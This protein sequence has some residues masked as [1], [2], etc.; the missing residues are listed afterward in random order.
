[1]KNMKI[2]AFLLFFLTVTGNV[3]SQNTDPLS[4]HSSRQLTDTSYSVKKANGDSTIFLFER[5]DSASSGFSLPALTSGSVLFSNG[6][7]ISQDNSNL[8]WDNSNKKLGIG[9]SS[10]SVPL[11][12]RVDGLANALSLKSST[13]ASILDFRNANTN[14]TPV[15]QINAFNCMVSLY[16]GLLLRRPNNN[17]TVL[18]LANPS[19]VTIWNAQSDGRTMFGS[20][21]TPS[22]FVHII[23]STGAA[24]MA[25]IK[26]NPGVKLIIPEVGAIE[27]D[28]VTNHLYWTD[29]FINR[30]QLDNDSVVSFSKNT[31]GDSIVLTFQ[32]GKRWAAKDSIGEGNVSLITVSKHQ[33]DSLISNNILIPGQSYMIKGVD[34][35]LY[36]GTDIILKAATV[37]K[38]ELSGHGIFY[39]PKYNQGKEDYGVW[40]NISSWTTSGI[41]G[42]FKGNEAVTAQNG[43]KGTT[44]ST[45]DGNKFVSI[46]GNWAMATSITGDLSAATANV[47]SITIKTFTIGDTVIWGGRN[48]KN[49]TGNTGVS[50]NELNLNADWEIV[51]YDSTNYNVSVDVI[52]YDYANDLIIKRED[53]NGNIVLNTKNEV[54]A[55]PNPRAIAVF[56]W[57]NPYNETTLKGCGNNKI[58]NGYA[59]VVNL[60]GCFAN[61]DVS[62]KSSFYQNNCYI[63]K[64]L[65]NN[66]RGGSSIASNTLLN[67]SIKSN[68]LSQ[69]DNDNATAPCTITSNIISGSWIYGNTLLLT[70]SINNNVMSNASYIYNNLISTSSA[71][72]SNNMVGAY[73]YQN[74]ARISSTINSN[75]MSS[76]GYIFRNELRITSNI[77]SNIMN[78]TNGQIR[79]NILNNICKINSN[80][81]GAYSV[82]HLNQLSQSSEITSD[83]ITG[84]NSSY[85]TWIYANVLTKGLIKNNTISNTA[86]IYNNHLDYITYYE[87]LTNITRTGWSE[88]SNNTLNGTN[89]STT[90]ASINGCVLRSGNIKNVII[91]SNTNIRYADIFATGYDFS[92]STLPGSLINLKINNAEAIYNYKITFTGAA[93][94]GQIGSVTLPVFQVPAGY[95]ISEVLV[96]VGTGLTGTNAKINLG[97]ET[98]APSAGLNDTT[99]DIAT[100]NTAK[101]TKIS[102]STF[103]KA[104]AARKLTMTVKDA[105]IT[106][107]TILLIIRL[108]KFM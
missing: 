28:S 59:D 104:T 69:G 41:I 107:G 60:I 5:G 16:N 70:S 52:E 17:G 55:W 78:G 15:A 65:N 39:N 82:I 6:T 100:L 71:I 26:L 51:P 45:I 25:P 64:F 49:V 37:N 29:K 76:V 21:A 101:L 12:V 7:T 95:F 89:N 3:F 14:T 47:T 61:N 9:T 91:P 43:A 48:W 50:I 34:T 80:T 62:E 74:E 10:P 58:I 96:D 32:S 53:K 44:F 1:M 73:I 108:T 42:T 13:G 11:E 99:G 46:S 57:G 83:T 106:A 97:I 94:N 105:D 72:N 24:G 63:G 102:L 68:Y 77:N 84:G 4:Y 54:T 93:N 66:L 35:T 81:I 36:G 85:F 56:Q 87:Q 20:S 38:F 92:S 30:Y 90:S 40:N 31:G 19:A 33:A 103:T 75:V 67:S 18:A 86:A 8:F 27:N 98:D 22:A 23:A 2:I 79:E 88:I